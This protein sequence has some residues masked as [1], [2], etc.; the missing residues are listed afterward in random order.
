LSFE[1]RTA[2]SMKRTPRTPWSTLGTCRENGSGSRPSI[3]AA[4][5]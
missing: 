2:A 1:E 4:I 5:C 3:R